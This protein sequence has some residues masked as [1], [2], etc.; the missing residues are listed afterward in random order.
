MEKNKQKSIRGSTTTNPL[1]GSRGTELTQLTQLK[2][3]MTDQDELIDDIETGVNQLGALAND[4]NEK[5]K[6]QGELVD[7][8]DKGVTEANDKVKFVTG[9]VNKMIENSG[10][11]CRCAIIVFLVVAFLILLLVM[12]FA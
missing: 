2:N 11:Q 3:D 12:V 9:M 8:L 1:H 10:G 7:N 4:M 5:S 6:V